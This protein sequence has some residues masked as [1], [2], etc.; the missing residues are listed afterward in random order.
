M[1][2]VSAALAAEPGDGHFVPP[3]N[4]RVRQ[5]L[6]AHGMNAVVI[7]NQNV[8]GKRLLEG[9]HRGATCYYTGNFLP[10]QA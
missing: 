4:R 10:A 7:G 5:G 1:L 9:L 8:Q 6:D 3:A 2:A